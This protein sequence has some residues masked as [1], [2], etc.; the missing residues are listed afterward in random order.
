[1][2]KT[3]N[4]ELIESCIKISCFDYHERKDQCRDRIFENNKK[5]RF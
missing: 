4:D 3:Q 2:L 5:E 1:M